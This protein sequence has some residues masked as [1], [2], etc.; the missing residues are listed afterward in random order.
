MSNIS[1]VYC[2][3]NGEEFLE[4][5]LKS[6]RD[7][8]DEI[9]VVDLESTDKTIEIAKKYKV[10]IFKH[11]NL[12]YVEPVRNFGISK[13]TGDWILV[14]DPD[15]ELSSELKNLLK[16]EINSST[17]EP[18][19]DY[20]RLPRKN[21]IFG[22]WIE[23][24]GWWPD[25][26]IRFFRKDYVSWNEVIHSVPMT[27]GKGYDV[28]AKEEFAIIHN[29]YYS[30]ESYFEKMLRYSKVQCDELIKGGYIFKWQDLILKPFGEFLSRFFAWQGYKDGLHGLMLSLL[31]AFSIL[32]VYLRIWEQK[33]F[34]QVDIDENEYIAL[35][36]RTINDLK[37]WI[38]KEFTWLKRLKFLS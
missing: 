13:A 24:S 6:I 33:K 22:K 16:N 4:K 29:N 7:F 15:E 2:I 9:I 14:L 11:K 18:R 31:Q 32:F 17:V 19:A 10:K 35:S 21:I 20:Y 26:N 27:Q 12:R 25:Y 28:E 30:I 8:A 1:A 38:R 36:K 23:H 5:S 37:W 34:V 3:H